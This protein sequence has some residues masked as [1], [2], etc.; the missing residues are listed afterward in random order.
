[1][2]ARS[3]LAPAEEGRVMEVPSVPQGEGEGTEIASKEARTARAT[4]RDLTLLGP[5][6]P[7]HPARG[8]SIESGRRCMRADVFKKK[9]D[10]VSSALD[11]LCILFT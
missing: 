10:M 6:L 2:Q 9:Q 3:D 11:R 7:L 1:M 5:E 8:V 4:N